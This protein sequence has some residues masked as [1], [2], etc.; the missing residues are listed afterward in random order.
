MFQPV[1]FGRL[2]AEE[3]RAIGAPARRRVYRRLERVE[4]AFTGIPELHLDLPRRSWLSVT[5]AQTDRYGL[6]LWAETES[7]QQTDAIV[8]RADFRRNG[9]TW[10]LDVPAELLTPQVVFRW[11]IVAPRERP[12]TITGA[13]ANVAVSGITAP[14]SLSVGNGQATVLGAT[15]TDI[16]AMPKGDA[17]WAGRRGPVRVEAELDIYFKITNVTFDGTLDARSLQSIHVWLPRGFASG[18]EADIARDAALVCRAD[19]GRA[20][21]RT[22]DGRVV[23]TYGARPPQLRLISQAGNI[24]IDNSAQDDDAR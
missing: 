16:R 24:I 8:E 6:V 2:P 12:V 21:R 15:A 19:L 23:Y 20:E 4:S 3:V 5:G 17:I 18:I 13:D 10:A 11:D 9:D 14:V 7:E 1:R 22:N